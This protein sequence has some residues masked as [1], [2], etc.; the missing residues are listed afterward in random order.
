MQIVVN[1]QPRTLNDGLTLA[2]LVA[3]L[4]LTPQRVAIEVNE[5]LVRRTDYA[6]TR[7]CDGD[8]IEVVTLVGGG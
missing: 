3:A 7:L 1:G 8:R 4:E 6:S 2:D 5:Q